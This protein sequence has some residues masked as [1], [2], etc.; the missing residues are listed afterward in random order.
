MVA[1]F[2]YQRRAVPISPNSDPVPFNGAPFISP[3]VFFHAL[4]AGA[5]SGNELEVEEGSGRRM[6][7]RPWPALATVAGMGPGD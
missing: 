4:V 3:F 1:L 6:V 2:P 7:E 5:G